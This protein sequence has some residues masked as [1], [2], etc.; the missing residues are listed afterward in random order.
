MSA[1]PENGNVL[2]KANQFLPKELYRQRRLTDALK[3]W[4]LLGSVL[5]F[6]PIMWSDTGESNVFAMKYL[7]AVWGVLI[8]GAVLLNRWVDDPPPTEAQQLERDAP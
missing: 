1:P 4:P 3:L 2:P 6:L 5:F 7:F 8:V